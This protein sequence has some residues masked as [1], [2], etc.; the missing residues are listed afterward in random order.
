MFVSVSSILFM[1]CQAFCAILLLIKYV[2]LLAL[3]ECGNNISNVVRHTM[4][5]AFIDVFKIINSENYFIIFIELD[6]DVGYM[7]HCVTIWDSNGLV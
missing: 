5:S 4:G 1:T 2:P 7:G 3:T 6:Y